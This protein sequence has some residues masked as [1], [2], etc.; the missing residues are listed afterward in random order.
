[1]VAPSVRRIGR[2]PETGNTATGCG[3]GASWGSPSSVSSIKGYFT[4]G[5]GGDGGLPKPTGVPRPGGRWVE[6]LPQGPGTGGVVVLVGEVRLHHEIACAHEAQQRRHR[7]GVERVV[8]HVVVERVEQVRRPRRAVGDE[9]PVDL[10]P[11]S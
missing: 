9:P 8:L 3:Y 10:G 4:G 6:L 7:T 1:M 11:A 5:C 2:A